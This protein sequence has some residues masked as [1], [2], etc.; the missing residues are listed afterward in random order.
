MVDATLKDDNI[1]D[2][3]VENIREPVRDL[4]AEREAADGFMRWK[5]GPELIVRVVVRLKEGA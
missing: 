5:K 1:Q 3:V 2:A 4:V